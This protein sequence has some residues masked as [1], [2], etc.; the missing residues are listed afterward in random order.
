MTFQEWVR[1][2]KIGPGMNDDNPGV[3]KFVEELASGED[4]FS[5]RFGESSKE[6]IKLMDERFY[7]GFDG[8]VGEGWLPILDRLTDDL[9]KMG[10]DRNLQQVKE[11]FGTLRFYIGT[12]TEEMHKRISEAEAETARTCEMCGAPGTRRTDGWVKTN[13]DECHVKWLARYGT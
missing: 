9:V 8:C 5:K 1:K 6:Q 2:W 13:C 3:R 12:G 4:K 10:W 7:S 11:K